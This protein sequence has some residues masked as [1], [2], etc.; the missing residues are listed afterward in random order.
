MQLRGGPDLDAK[1]ITPMV[2]QYQAIKEQYPD[3][4]LMFRLGFPEG[5]SRRDF[6]HD[7]AGP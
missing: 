6:G 1:K 2:E 7:L 4:I 5:S 3:V